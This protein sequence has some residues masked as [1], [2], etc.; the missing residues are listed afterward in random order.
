LDHPTAGLAQ[1]GA[2]RILVVAGESG[3]DLLEVHR[4]IQRG[5]V[6]RQVFVAGHV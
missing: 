1:L 2:Q 5:L 4:R 3:Y 6:N